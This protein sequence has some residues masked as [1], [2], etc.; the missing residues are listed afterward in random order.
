MTPRPSRSFFLPVLVGLFALAGACSASEVRRAASEGA[1]L[2]DRGEY[3]AALPF[4]EKAVAGGLEDG[5]VFYQ[6]GYIYDLKSMGEKARK[7]REKAIP[8]LEKRAGSADATL[9]NSYYLTALYSNLQRPEEVKRAAERGVAKFGQ[10]QGLSGSDL[11]RLGRLYQFLG[12]GELGAA[13]YRKAVEAFGKER[14]PGPVLYSLALVAD[15][16]TDLQARR[17]SDAGRKFER[18]AQVNTKLPA[19]SFEVALA[20]LGAGEFDAAADGFARVRDASTAIE[21]QYGADVARRLKAAGGLVRGTPDGKPLAELENSTLQQ[22]IQAAADSLRKARLGSE[23]RKDSTHSTRE[24][25]HL[26]FNLVAEWM[27]RGNAI[28][29]TALAAGYADLIRR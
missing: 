7:Y 20:H 6:L 16:R 2:Y 5:E 10:T 12:R 3:D 24:E 21:A 28:R 15:A 19:A 13:T 18:A 4:L 22:A 17:Y 11:F 26:F 25:E 29:E 23:A 9:E 27:L 1:V 8:L 14:D